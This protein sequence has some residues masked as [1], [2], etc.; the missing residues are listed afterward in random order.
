LPRKTIGYEPAFYIRHSATR[1][2][3]SGHG[4]PHLWGG[5]SPAHLRRATPAV[6]PP[7]Y[8][9]LQTY[10]LQPLHSATHLVLSG[11][12]KPNLC[13]GTSDNL[14]VV[15]GYGGPLLSGGT[16]PPNC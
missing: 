8:R 5:T 2:V 6:R 13:G 15:P 7:R 4:G 14:H 3:L 16:S 1:P 12:G 9:A 11:C 10:G